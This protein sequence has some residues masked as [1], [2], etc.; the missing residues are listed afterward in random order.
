[1][2]NNYPSNFNPD[3]EPTLNP[4]KYPASYIVTLLPNPI[5]Y[6]IEAHNEDSAI[7]QALEQFDDD[8]PDLIVEDYK[9]ED[10]LLND[11]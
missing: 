7:E 8:H 9:V 2:N 11:Y 10:N 1:M 4:D 6:E 3:I 5:S